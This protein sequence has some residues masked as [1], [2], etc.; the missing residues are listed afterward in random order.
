MRRNKMLPRL[1]WNEDFDA[2]A[3]MTRWSKMH[4]IRVNK[5]CGRFPPTIKAQSEGRKVKQCLLRQTCATASGACMCGSVKHMLKDDFVWFAVKCHGTR[6]KSL[7]AWR[8]IW[9][10]VC[11]VKYDNSGLGC[12]VAIQQESSKTVLRAFPSPSGCCSHLMG[13]LN[14]ENKVDGYEAKAKVVT[15]VL[16]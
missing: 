6:K 11:G 13:A 4:L 10:A 2:I 16:R 3:D 5:R 8:E 7:R 14:L 1:P 12:A 15:A 9:C